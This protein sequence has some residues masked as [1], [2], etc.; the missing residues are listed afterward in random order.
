MEIV[1]LLAQINNTADLLGALILLA[2]VVLVIASLWVIFTKAGQ[3]GWASLI[4]VYNLYV[5][6]Q[7]VGKP[8]WWLFLFLIPVINLIPSILLNFDLA[9]SF[10]KGPGFALGLIFLPMIFLP[11]L[12][13]SDATYAGPSGSQSN[14]LQNSPKVYGKR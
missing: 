8:A 4:P 12:A 1:N 10:R 5:M 6:L 13:F 2:L 11:I 7:I 9:R 3:P 14:V